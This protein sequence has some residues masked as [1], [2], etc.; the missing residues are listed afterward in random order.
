MAVTEVADTLPSINTLRAARGT[1]NRTVFAGAPIGSVLYT[2]F[3][4]SSVA[5]GKWQVVH[6]FIESTDLHL[7]QFACKNSMDEVIVNDYRN[8]VYVLWRQPFPATFNFYE[9]S[10]NFIGVI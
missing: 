1:R 8:A 10:R 6:E 4:L 5:A 2:G 9:L 7:V 3:S